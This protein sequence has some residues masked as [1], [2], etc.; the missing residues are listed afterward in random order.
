MVA[1]KSDNNSKKETLTVQKMAEG[2]SV[3]DTRASPKSQIFTLQSELAR[4]FFGFK[5]RWKTCA[6]NP[7]GKNIRATFHRNQSSKKTNLS[8]YI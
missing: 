6:E 8:V 2:T 4:I 1:E 3:N 7:K 5:S